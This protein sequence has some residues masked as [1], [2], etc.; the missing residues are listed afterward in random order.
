MQTKITCANG[1]RPGKWIRAEMGRLHN[2]G[3][4]FALA[5]SFDLIV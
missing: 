2:V 3:L 5:A 4:E 1:L